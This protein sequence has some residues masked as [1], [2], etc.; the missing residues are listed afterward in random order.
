MDLYTKAVSV[1]YCPYVWA[2]STLDWKAVIFTSGSSLIRLP[3]DAGENLAFSY[4]GV[5]YRERYDRYI[6]QCSP[7]IRLPLGNGKSDLIRGVG[8]REEY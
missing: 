4:R 7:F 5:A 2:I 1:G 3:L 6:I 8:P